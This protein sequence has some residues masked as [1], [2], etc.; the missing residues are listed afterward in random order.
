MPKTSRGT[1]MHPI[2]LREVNV[3]RTSDLTPG[4][5]RVT[6]A[7][8]QLDAFTSDNGLDQPAFR[9]DGFDDEIRL[10]FP[11]PGQSEPLLP[12]QI[13]G[14]VRPADEGRVLSRAYTVRRWDPARG[15][16]DVDFVKH[17]TGVATTW[18]ERAEPG[19]GIHFFGP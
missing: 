15:E 4:M 7:G 14:S 17:G 10:V 8:P 2:S 3:V 19:D 11:H 16:L 1:T 12:V 13:E 6:L 5:R 9:T 18:A